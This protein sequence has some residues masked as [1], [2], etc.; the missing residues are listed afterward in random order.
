M[1]IKRAKEMGK[2][3]REV[4]RAKK[5]TEQWHRKEQIQLKKEANGR[6]CGRRIADAKYD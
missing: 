3:H 4:P 5:E 2:K 6:R 1:D